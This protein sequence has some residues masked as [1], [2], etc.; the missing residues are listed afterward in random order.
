ML[1]LLM[2]VPILI[3]AIIVIYLISIYNSL[4]ARKNAAVASWHQID[5]QLTRRADLVGNL[6]ET[7]KGYAAHEKTVF[8]D[9]AVARSS[10][11]ES[12][13]ARQAGEASSALDSAL[14]RLFAVAESY[15]ELKANTNFLNLQGQLT[16]LE[17]TIASARQ[18]YNDNVRLYNITV[19]QFPA[20]AFAGS[21]GFTSMDYFE[22]PTGKAEPPKV[23]FL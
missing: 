14:A 22:A 18:Y 11:R 16:E 19:Q 2:L 13:G 17:N 23:S 15:P 4:V 1:L 7:V 21:F 5:V 3:L 20:N 10:I 6:V 12:R 9:I 8:E